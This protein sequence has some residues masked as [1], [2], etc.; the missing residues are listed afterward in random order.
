[1]QVKG[2]KWNLLCWEEVITGGMPLGTTVRT[3]DTKASKKIIKLGR[4]FEVGK[5][6]L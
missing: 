6:E 2:E 5:C 4:C 1:M 3:E